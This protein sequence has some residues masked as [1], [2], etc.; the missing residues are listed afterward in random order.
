[1]NLS[2]FLT[3]SIFLLYLALML[4]IGIWA[5]RKTRTIPDFLLASRSLGKWLTAFSSVASS[6]SGWAILGTTG[7]AYKEGLASIWFMPGCL[8][9]YILNWYLVAERLRRKSLQLKA[10]T[11]PDYLEEYFK[12]SSH[13][14]RVI[15][16]MVISI[17]MLAYVSAQLTAVGKAFQAIFGIS[18]AFSVILGGGIVILYTLL[19]GFRA[20]VWTDLIQGILMVFALVFLPIIALIHIGGF[21]TLF[22]KISLIENAL[23]SPFGKREGIALLGF[24]FGLL[25]IGLGYPGQP[26]VITRFMAARDRKAIQGGKII[27]LSWGLLVYSGAILLGLSGRTL[28]PQISD[29]EYIFPKI[30]LLLLSPILSGV[31]LSAVMSA[32]M[33]T[34]DSQLLVATSSLMRDFYQK[35][36][37]RKLDERKLLRLSRLS[38]LFLGILSIIFALTKTRIIFWFVLF[39]WSGLGASF[40]PIILFTLFQPNLPKKA[41]IMGMLTGFIITLIWKLTGLSEKLI[42]EL[43]PAFLF[44]F[45]VIWLMSRKKRV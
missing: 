26:H 17:F 24:I 2:P 16:V 45:L 5:Q 22:S 12:D 4:A 23:L 18:Y 42:Y 35:T 15:A 31:M 20:V 37:Q 8:L 10:L 14:I 6:E 13:S 29:P 38:L 28:I 44:S 1:M 30:S 7:L 3:G 39:A 34:A 32:I 25:G 36:L 40:G 9:G 41:G 21:S 19:G 27:A 43:I 11:I 33:S